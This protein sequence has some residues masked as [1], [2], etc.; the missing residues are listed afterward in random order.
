MFIEERYLVG[1]F[2]HRPGRTWNGAHVDMTGNEKREVPSVAGTNRTIR[3]I[4]AALE[5]FDS[6]L[7]IGHENPDDDCIAAMVSVGL[8]ISKMGKKVQVDLCANFQEQFRYLLNICRYNSIIVHEGDQKPDLA[9]QAIIVI[10]TPKPQMIGCASYYEGV[11]ADPGILKIEIDHHLE[12][13]SSFSGDPGYRFVQGS[14]SSCE[15]VSI[16]L[17][18]LDRD[19]AFMKRWGLSDLFE[20]NVI[21]CLLTGMIADSHM[22]TYLKTPRERKFYALISSRLERMLKLKTRSGSGNF[23]NSGELFTAIASLSSAEES[24]FKALEAHVETGK[25]ISY[26]ILDEAASLEVFRLFGNDVLVSVSKALADSLAE[27]SGY[28]GLV[29]YYD[30]PSVSNFVQ[31]RLRRSQGFSGLDLRDL[32]GRLSIA[33]GGGHPGAI[34]FRFERSEFPDLGTLSSCLLPRIEKML[35]ETAQ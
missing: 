1:P 16:L 27:A 25:R 29:A 20:R 2:A 35:D 26:A 23:S 9:V 34:G 14:S 12:G 8:L 11:F 22:G 5:R 19:R 24:C 31:F 13:D 32:L 28:L 10:D 21:L 15:L 18:K 3:N 30:D 7:I 33:N 4:Q 6:F 17:F